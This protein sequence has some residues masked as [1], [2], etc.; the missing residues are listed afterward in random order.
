MQI[1]KKV[2][3]I[4]EGYIPTWS[5]GKTPELISHEAACILNTGDMDAHIEL[6]IYFEDK[7]PVGPYKITVGAK[8]T[9]HMRF[10]NLS[11]PERIPLG[12]PYSSVFVSDVPVIIQHTRLDSRQKENALLTT[13]AYFE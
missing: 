9:I 13:I 12:T 1:G 7:S 11:V 2:W 8:R 4:A 5:T 6:M 3:A 10:N